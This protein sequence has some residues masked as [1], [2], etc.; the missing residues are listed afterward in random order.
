MTLT[1]RKALSLIPTIGAGLFGAA[2]I[3]TRLPID[4]ACATKLRKFTASDKFVW[5]PDSELR[6]SVIVTIG[7]GGGGGGKV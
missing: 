6:E 1:R 7:V 3:P 5:I 2:A 4:P